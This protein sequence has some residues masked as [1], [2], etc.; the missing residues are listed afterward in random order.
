MRDYKRVEKKGQDKVK[1]LNINQRSL[2]KVKGFPRVG[3]QTFLYDIY[4]GQ[5]WKNETCKE[6]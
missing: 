1:N 3:C 6:S 2:T 4:C 5:K